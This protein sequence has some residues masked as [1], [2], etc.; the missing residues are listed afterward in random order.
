L[1]TRRWLLASAQTGVKTSDD[2]TTTPVHADPK[3]CDGLRLQTYSKKAGIRPAI[4]ISSPL[5]LP[6]ARSA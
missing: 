4:L 1:L 3:E 6:R 2:E 5:A